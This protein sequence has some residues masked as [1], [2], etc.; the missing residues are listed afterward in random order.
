MSTKLDVMLYW[1][2]APPEPSPGLRKWMAKVRSGWS[3]NRRISGMDYH[4]KAEFFNVYIWEYLN[5]L[6][7]A[8]EGSWWAGLMNLYFYDYQANVAWSADIEQWLDA[9]DKPRRDE[10]MAL[11]LAK[12]EG[13]SAEWPVHRSMNEWCWTN[14]YP[15]GDGA[16]PAYTLYAIDQPV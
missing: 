7:P 9:L 4:S 1:T 16:P 6:R 13:A 5:I 8:L 12:S 3:P 14:G 10:L 11:A 15:I 2:S